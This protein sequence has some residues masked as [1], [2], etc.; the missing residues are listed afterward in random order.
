M[1][2]CKEKDVSVQLKRGCPIAQN[3][4]STTHKPLMQAATILGLSSEAAR[5]PSLRHSH[6]SGQMLI[7]KGRHWSGLV[8][9]LYMNYYSEIYWELLTGFM[10]KGDKVK[11]ASVLSK[12]T[13]W[14]CRVILCVSISAQIGV[15]QGALVCVC[16]CTDYTHTPTCTD[17]QETFVY[18]FLSA[19]EQVH[20]V[21]QAPIPLGTE[22]ASCDSKGSS[23]MVCA[24][25]YDPMKSATTLL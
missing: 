1:S 10:G 2:A 11:R 13:D 9:S 18:A 16:I 20:T 15:L 19:G 21:Q 17:W 5:H 12:Q 4:E 25:H 6:D 3:M 7:D 8:I 14:C 24:A 23:K 22:R